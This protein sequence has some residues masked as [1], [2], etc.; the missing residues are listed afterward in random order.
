[1]PRVSLLLMTIACRLSM[2]KQKSLRVQI[3]GPFE[4]DLND[5][6]HKSKTSG[7]LQFVCLNL[8]AMSASSTVSYTASKAY[9]VMVLVGLIMTILC[10]N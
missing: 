3:C 4:G 5:C 7:P 6:W 2:K 9:W 8:T 1:M 10:A